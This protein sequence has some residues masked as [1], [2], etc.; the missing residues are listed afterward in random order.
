MN[1]Q[2]LIHDGSRVL[3]CTPAPGYREQ[4]LTRV[5]KQRG[6]DDAGI[7]NLVPAGVPFRMTYTAKGYALT[8]AQYEGESNGR[9]A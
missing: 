8:T 2:W 3:P 9:Q 5:P 6:A 7:K 4:W 1:D